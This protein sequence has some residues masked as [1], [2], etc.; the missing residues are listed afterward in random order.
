M[1]EIIRYQ[2]RFKCC[3]FK[4]ISY[5]FS[6]VVVVVPEQV[7]VD[8]VNKP[9]NNYSNN[10]FHVDHIECN[11]FLRLFAIAQGSLMLKQ[12][13]QFSLY[14]NR[15]IEL[16]FIVLAIISWKTIKI[17]IKIVFFLLICLRIYWS[18]SSIG[19]KGV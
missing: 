14:F 11:W 3:I 9:I 15:N 5:L 16:E 2:I 19:I 1:P 4:N 12:C 18:F 10:K 13:Q 8:P 6:I 17:W 7:Q